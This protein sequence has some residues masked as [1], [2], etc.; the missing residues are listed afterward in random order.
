MWGHA[1]NSSHERVL[2]RTKAAALRTGKK[3]SY[4]KQPTSHCRNSI[5][6]GRVVKEEKL[7]WEQG[8]AVLPCWRKARAERPLHEDAP[9]SV[10]G[11]MA[12]PTQHSRG[13]MPSS[14]LGV[15][16]K[17][18]KPLPVLGRRRRRGEKKGERRWEVCGRVRQR[19]NAGGPGVSKEP[20]RGQATPGAAGR[21]KASPTEHY[22]VRK[23]LS[24][25][26]E[27]LQES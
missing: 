20:S 11:L 7:C 18:P 16:G 8:C 9:L 4:W 27:L 24:F 3:R 14:G 23:F 13:E 21:T 6:E 5:K 2:N 25:F 26:R 10:A 12:S 19:E 15:G 1:P 17:A 22:Q